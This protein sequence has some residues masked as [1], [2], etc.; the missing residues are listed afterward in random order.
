MDTK[1]TVDFLQILGHKDIKEKKHDPVVLF[2]GLERLGVGF[3][4]WDKQN[5]ELSFENRQKNL[6]GC[7]NPCNL[8]QVFLKAPT[9]PVRVV[10]L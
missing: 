5:V 1:S 3:S 8:N 2:I 10:Y 9:E 7:A 4:V 6:L